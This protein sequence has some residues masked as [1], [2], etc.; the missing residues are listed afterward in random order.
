[1]N[2]K[3]LVR[4]G[5]LNLGIYIFLIIV[6]FILTGIVPADF[7]NPE[8]ISGLRLWLADF[9]SLMTRYLMVAGYLLPGKM[10]YTLFGNLLGYLFGFFMTIPF[11][12]SIVGIIRLLKGNKRQ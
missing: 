4:F 5:L 3:K 2:K 8:G 12:L 9:G 11:S 6:C 10:S 7:D 1:M